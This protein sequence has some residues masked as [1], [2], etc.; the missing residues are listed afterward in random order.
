MKTK[1]IFITLFLSLVIK[2]Y[3]QSD[4][5][6]FAISTSAE[7]VQNKGWKYSFGIDY[8]FPIKGV[9]NIGIGAYYALAKYSLK[10]EEFFYSCDI[11]DDENDNFIYKAHGKD[12]KEEHT[13]HFV[14][15]PIYYHLRLK[16]FFF[17]VGPKIAIPVKSEYNVVKGNV[18]LTGFYPQYNVELTELPNHGFANYNIAGYQGELDTQIVWGANVSLGYCLPLGSIDLNIRAFAEYMFNDYVNIG[19]NFLEY[20]G[21][22]NS[23]SYVNDKSSNLSLGLSLG[24]GLW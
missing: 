5:K 21:K 15:I 10:S 6:R 9:N 7:N 8:I 4:F 23:Y 17:N 16:S 14:E 22:I 2:G 20:P 1:I 12:I 13:I 18:E 11:V 3:A 24:L 19:K